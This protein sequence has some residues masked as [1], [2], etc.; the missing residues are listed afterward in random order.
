MPRLVRLLVFL[1]LLVVAPVLWADLSL[2]HARRAQALLGPDIWS[3]LIRIENGARASHYPRTLHALVFELA[4]LLW[5]YTAVNGTQSFSLHVGRL[6]EEKADFGPLLR[7]IEPG[8]ARWSVVSPGRRPKPAPEGEL[9]NGCFI[10]SVAELRMRLARG[11]RLERPRLLSYYAETP[12][13]RSGH[14]VLVFGLGDQL[15]VFDPGRPQARTAFAKELAPDALA[16]ARAIEG[17]AIVKARYVAI[18]L[19]VPPREAE[20][21]TADSRGRRG[22]AKPDRS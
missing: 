4:G 21:A 8:F 22:D 17:A 11:E 1:F 15:E 3:R 16:L 18:D 5:F 13:G 9:G 6:A 14:T 7:D 19:A 10:E 2:D 20:I 12:L